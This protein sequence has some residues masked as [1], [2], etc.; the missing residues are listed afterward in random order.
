MRLW[1]VAMVRHEADV[2]VGYVRYTLYVLDGLAIVD[3]SS[4]DGTAEIL[5]NLRREGLPLQICHD[6]EPSFQQS[7]R[8]TQMARKTLAEE[9]ADFVFALD[10]DEFLRLPDRER[11]ERALRDVPREMHAVAHWPTYVPRFVCGWRAVRTWSPP[12]Q[13][14]GRAPHGGISLRSSSGERCWSGRTTGSARVIISSARR[15]TSRRAATRGCARTSLPLPIVRSAAEA[16]SNAKS[17]W[18]IL[19][20]RRGPRSRN[21][22]GFTGA[23]CT[24]TCAPASR[25]RRNVCWRLPATTGFRA[26]YG[27]PRPRLN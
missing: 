16:S 21:R 2:M 24:R 12:T 20:T 8:I 25:L 7:L 11:V 23:I 3:H 6:H 27:F 10:A 5:T 4:F 14:E 22:S 1:G 18:A 26:T 15:T 19:P 13:V 9:G 17:S